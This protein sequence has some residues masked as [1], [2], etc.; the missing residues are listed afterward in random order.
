MYCDM[1]RTCGNTTGGWTRVANLDMTDPSQQCPVGFTL[2]NRMQAPLRTCGGTGGGTCDS[3]TFP[4]YGIEYS[5]V[6]GR[7]RGYQVGT[8][9]AFSRSIVIT[10]TTID[11]EPSYVDGISLTHGQ[12]PRTHIWTFAAGVNQVRT[13]RFGCPCNQ[14][15][16]LTL[17]AFL[18]QDYFCDSGVP[19]GIQH[20]VFFP[21]DPLWDGQGCVPQSAC[22]SFNNPP[23][24]SNEQLVPTTEDIELRLCFDESNTGENIPFEVVEI[25]IN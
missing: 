12:S 22:C 1:N 17:P 5:H 16:M 20:G 25:Y 11:S 6:C 13:D 14:Q 23:W 21:S 3:T 8:P 4:V 9:E 15:N 24:F 2:L 10:S 7:V 19:T 18:G